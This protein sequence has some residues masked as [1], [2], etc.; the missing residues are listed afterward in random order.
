MN[1]NEKTQGFSQ[2]IH[3]ISSTQRE[4]L[5]TIRRIGGDVFRYCRAGATALIPG[6][7]LQPAYFTANH[8]NRSAVAT[9]KG[10]TE[11]TFT[12]GATEVTADMY[13]DGY[14]QVN[15]GTSG[16]LGRQWKIK[17]H[18]VV[19]AAGG[20]ITVQ[21]DRPLDVALVVTTDKLSLIP[22]PFSSVTEGAVAKGFAGIAPM[23]VT[24][25]YYFWAQVGGVA[26]AILTNTVAVGSTLV[27]GATGTL[28]LFLSD[29][30]QPPVGY[31]LNTGVTSEYKTVYLFHY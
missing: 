26:L 21:L 13:K 2:G 10:K 8:I 11:V 23:P 30:V 7:A 3:Q 9:A 22:N 20:S 28:V 6:V 24:A 12:V 25:L 29:Y 15:A 31:V 16:T 5:G 19:A 17:S 18:S 27:P 1:Q 14:L 4:Q